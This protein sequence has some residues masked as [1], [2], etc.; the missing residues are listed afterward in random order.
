[1]SKLIEFTKIEATGNDFIFIDAR[2]FSESM[3]SASIIK[4]MC[5]RH[6]GIGADGLIFID[7][8]Q[9]GAFSMNYY[10]SDGLQANM[11]AN[12]GRSAVRKMAAWDVFSVSGGFLRNPADY[13]TA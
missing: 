2:K 4:E 9:E 7:N 12:G 11:C 13:A 10:N 1:M 8:H 5:D 6:F 3:F